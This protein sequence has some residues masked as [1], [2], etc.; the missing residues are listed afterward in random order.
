MIK[1][2]YLDST[3][4]SYLFDKRESLKEYIRITQKG[5]IF[6]SG[7]AKK[8]KILIFGFQKKQ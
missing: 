7:G 1:T 5:V 4:P 6:K 2:V 8:V 3:I